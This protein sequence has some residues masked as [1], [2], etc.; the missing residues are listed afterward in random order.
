V[1][2]CYVGDTTEPSGDTTIDSGDTTSDSLETTAETGEIT[3]NPEITVSSE[4]TTMITGDTT[5]IQ[6]K[7]TLLQKR[8]CNSNFK[9]GKCRPR[10]MLRVQVKSIDNFSRIQVSNAISKKINSRL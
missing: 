7:A 4:E 3:A 8:Q 2:Y 6:L 1:T 10:L 5:P 9:H